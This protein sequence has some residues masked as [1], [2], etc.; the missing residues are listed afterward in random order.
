MAKIETVEI[1]YVDASSLDDKGRRVVV[2]EGTVYNVIWP[3]DG[4]TDMDMRLLGISSEDKENIE[5]WLGT[6]SKHCTG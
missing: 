4:V 6:C 2:C 1:L 5:S 3:V